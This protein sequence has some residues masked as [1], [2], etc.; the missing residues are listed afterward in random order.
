MRLKS[1]YLRCLGACLF[2]VGIIGL[3]VDAAFLGNGDW[4]S[5]KASIETR[6]WV[7]I[8]LSSTAFVGLALWTFGIFRSEKEP[9][10][11]EINIID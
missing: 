8:V 4:P 9:D 10:F 1:S 5:I 3:V 6:S 2:G 7:G 11:P